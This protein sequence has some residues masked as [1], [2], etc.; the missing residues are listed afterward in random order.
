M[1]IIMVNKFL[2]PRGG[3]ETYCL[4]IGKFLEDAGHEVTYFGMWDEKNTASNAQGLYT[5]NMDF[6]KRSWRELF[7]PFR[8]LYSFEAKS[9]LQELIRVFRPDLIHLNNINFQ[10]TPSVIDAAAALN[11]PVVQT[12]HDFQMLCP[13]H[14]MLD[15]E[16]MQPCERCIGGN[17]FWCTARSCIHS[18]RVKSLLGSLEALLYRWHKSYA[19]VA[20]YICPS[21]FMQKMLH[22][23]V[24][25]RGKTR[26]LHNFIDSARTELPVKRDYVLYF[27]RLSGEKG[28][29]ILLSACERLPDV[30]FIIAGSGPLEELC[31]RC[32]LSNV[33]YVG[34]QSGAALETLIEQA[35]FSVYFPVWY[36]NC[37]LSVLESQSCGTP[38]LASAIGGIPELI[39]D[40]VTGRLLTRLDAESCAGEI[41][42]MWKD[43][44]ELHRMQQNC[45]GK[46]AEMTTLVGYTAQL[47]KIYEECLREHGKSGGKQ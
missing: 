24:L 41:G 27:G 46:S 35:A 14:M 32:G 26:V 2:Y 18:S 17:P 20:V 9:K 40:G 3:A 30:P 38:V 37:P 28:I 15:S 21:F 11:V 19:K 44:D 31:E 4:K 16:T 7:Y 6:R 1:K 47:V 8:I 34:F 22:R 43:K 10:L 33:T 12:V 29:E 39:E 23:R 13:N 36:E 25:Y 42:Q 45:I 5:A